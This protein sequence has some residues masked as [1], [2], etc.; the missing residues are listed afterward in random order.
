MDDLNSDEEDIDI[1]QQLNNNGAD[2]HW[3]MS[4]QKVM[5]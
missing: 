2:E 3:G 4:K 5:S 1:G